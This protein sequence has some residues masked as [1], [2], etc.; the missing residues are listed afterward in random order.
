MNGSGLDTVRAPR[1]FSAVSTTSSNASAMYSTFSRSVNIAVPVTEEGIAGRQ[2]VNDII[3]PSILQIKSRE[4]RANEIEALSTFEKGI[5][6]LDH[7]NPDL[8]L[9]TLV[10]ILSRMKTNV[11]IC[12]QLSDLGVVSDAF[13]SASNH[14]ITDNVSSSSSLPNGNNPDSNIVE[15]IPVAEGKPAKSPISEILSYP[16][17]IDQLRM[18][19]PIN[20]GSGS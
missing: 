9:T 14:T 4:L 20:L 10:E 18:K 16:R 8:V 12:E 5:E 17:W 11:K 13:L 2:L 19:W 15:E 1:P 3:L 6:E 7:A